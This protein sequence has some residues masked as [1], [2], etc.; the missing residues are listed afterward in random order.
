VRRRPVT[1]IGAAGCPCGERWDEEG[2]RGKEE[3]REGRR[4]VI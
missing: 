4:Y 3:R 1:G 2:R